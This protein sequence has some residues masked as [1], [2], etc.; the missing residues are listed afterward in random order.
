MT[1]GGHGFAFAYDLETLGE[2]FVNPSAF[3]YSLSGCYRFGIFDVDAG[4]EIYLEVKQGDKWVSHLI[5]V[6]P[7]IIEGVYWFD[8]QTIHYLEKRRDSLAQAT[9]SGIR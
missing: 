7:T 5:G 8:D 3:V 4:M 9:G 6:C 1:T 2:I